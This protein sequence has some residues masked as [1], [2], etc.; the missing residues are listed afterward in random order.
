MS[1]LMILLSAILTV[2]VLAGPSYAGGTMKEAESSDVHASSAYSE[3]E[4]LGLTVYN[5]GGDEVGTI[6]DVSVNSE[7]GEI[8]F[9]ILKTSGIFGLGGEEHPVPLEALN[10][11]T[12]VGNAT[13][14]VNEDKLED[15]PSRTA[16]VSDEEFRDTIH[17]YY[18]IA[19][20]FEGESE[21]EK[22]MKE[23][24]KEHPEKSRY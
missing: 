20:A 6:R 12:D 23:E 10:I 2:I 9:V 4:L 24:K 16:D 13:L 17:K 19:P 14:R 22:M 18:G 5:M 3:D 11:R 8:N 21:T 15:A 1:K 7:T